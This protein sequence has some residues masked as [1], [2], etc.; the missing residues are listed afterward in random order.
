M[1]GHKTCYDRHQA[2]DW[3]DERPKASTLSTLQDGISRYGTGESEIV[4]RVA[5]VEAFVRKREVRHDRVVQG[6]G[7]RGPGEP[8]RV[9]DLQAA[10]DAA[11]ELDAVAEAPALGLEDSEPGTGAGGYRRGVSQDVTEPPREVADHG[12]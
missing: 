2:E 7:E 3:C 6:L 1:G 12:C 9:D 11:G 10:D 4:A 8:G 5:H